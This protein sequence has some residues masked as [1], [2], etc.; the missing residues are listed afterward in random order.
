[1]VEEFLKEMSSAI[2]MAI[3]SKEQHYYILSGSK[4]LRLAINQGQI[5]NGIESEAKQNKKTTL[6]N[7]TEQLLLDALVLVRPGGICS[8]EAL[9][10]EKGLMGQKVPG[11]VVE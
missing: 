5:W 7:S 6:I 10:V 11:R 8:V 9:L 4:R 1:M 3:T 2:T